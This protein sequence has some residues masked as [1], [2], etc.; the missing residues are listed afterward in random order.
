MIKVWFDRIEQ[1]SGRAQSDQEAQKSW[2]G[3]LMMTFGPSDMAQLMRGLQA[4][5]SVV[6]LSSI[7]A[8]IVLGSIIACR[9]IIRAK[10]QGPRP[11]PPIFPVKADKGTSSLETWSRLELEPF[12]QHVVQGLRRSGPASSRSD[13]RQSLRTAFMS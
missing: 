10:R 8:G 4:T 9:Q 3:N 12:I 1:I 7:V 2:R 6:M 13:G 5:I 11:D